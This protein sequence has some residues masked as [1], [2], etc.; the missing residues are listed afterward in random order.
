MKIFFP[1][2]L[3]LVSGILFFLFVDPLYK[4]VGKLRTDVLTYNTAL[5]NSTNLQKTRDSLL[6]KYRNIS[7]EDK[8]RLNNFLPDT[9]N[10]I[11]FILEIEQIANLHSMPLKNIKFDEKVQKEDE[12]VEPAGNNMI[13]SKNTLKSTPYGV[14]PVEF[15]TEGT[16]DSFVLFLKDIERNLRIMDIKN[17]SFAV[18]QPVVKP[19]SGYDPNIY[20]YTLKVETY[21]LK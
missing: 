7:Q 2:A 17:I 5:G 10:N 21:W 4:E 14:F 13:I 19:E 3:I 6:E 12:E 20:S 16:Y 18:P 9:V 11:R 8:D 15:I 1:I